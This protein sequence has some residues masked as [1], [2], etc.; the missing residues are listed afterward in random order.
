MVVVT[1]VTLVA[2][3]VAVALAVAEEDATGLE[4]GAALSPE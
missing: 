2:V 3:A 1:F 4:E